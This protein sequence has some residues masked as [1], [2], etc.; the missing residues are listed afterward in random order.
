MYII[1]NKT[2]HFRNLK[3][4]KDERTNENVATV[5]TE[6][7]DNGEFI[8]AASSTPQFVPDWVVNDPMFELSKDDGSIL[9]VE[10]KNKETKS[11][12]TPVQQ[13]KSGWVKPEETGLESK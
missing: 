10:I 13:D 6:D 8:V 12:K 3:I 2:I 9:E 4:T 5:V 1:T 7:G 11:P